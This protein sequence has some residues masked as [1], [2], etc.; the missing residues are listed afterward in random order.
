MSLAINRKG[1]VDNLQSGEALLGGS[2]GLPFFKGHADIPPDP[3]DLEQARS[4]L[5]EAG[6]EA[7]FEVN[8]PVT[9]PVAE[10]VDV[11]VADWQKIGIQARVQ[12][13]EPGAWV[14]MVNGKE[15]PGIYI[16]PTGADYIDPASYGLFT[17]SDGTFSYLKDFDADA[18]ILVNGADDDERFKAWERIQRGV[19]EETYYANLWYSN[20]LTAVGNRV[21]EWE[22]IPNNGYIL[23]VEHLKL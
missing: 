21:K 20:A 22:P 1:I 5:R 12:P 2:F 4:L 17:F 3:Y 19:Y 6:L 13:L 7:G 16:E 11:L 23:L 8:F 9:S 14:N 18:T 10:Y 15:T